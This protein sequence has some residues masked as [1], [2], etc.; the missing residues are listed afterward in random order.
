MMWPLDTM[1]RRW[2]MLAPHVA[3]YGPRDETPRPAVILFHGCA[4]VRPHID[5]YAR[6]DLD[7]VWRPE[8]VWKDLVDQA[9]YGQV[10]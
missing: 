10:R 6:A 1:A 5:I 8:G 4:G 2:D 9:G 7:A 3:A